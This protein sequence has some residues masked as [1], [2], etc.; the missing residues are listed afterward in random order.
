MTGLSGEVL[1]APP[2]SDL[3][4]YDPT[5]PAVVKAISAAPQ[6]PRSLD[7]ALKALGDSPVFRATL[8]ASAVDSFIK[9][10]RRQCDEY[11]AQLTE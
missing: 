4:M 11:A 10:R 6:L 1:P 3:N 5:D 2:P 9:L 8:G 7:A